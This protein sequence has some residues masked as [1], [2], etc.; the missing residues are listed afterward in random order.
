MTA[1]QALLRRLVIERSDGEDGRVACKVC[2]VYLIDKSGSTVA[3]H[4][5]DERDSAGRVF[6][7]PTSYLGLFCRG[8]S[9]RLAGGSKYNEIV[10]SVVDDMVYDTPERGIIYLKV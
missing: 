5:G 3:A 10:R 2:V 4:S 9:R 7:G 1:V 6:D 8:Q